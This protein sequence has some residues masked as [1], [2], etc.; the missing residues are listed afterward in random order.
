MSLEQTATCLCLSAIPCLLPTPTWPQLS[1]EKCLSTVN[2]SKDKAGQQRAAVS[3][4]VYSHGI[5]LAEPMG[6]Q[7]RFPPPVS[8]ILRHLVAFH[9]SLVLQE[10]DAGFLQRLI[11][12]IKMRERFRQSQMPQ[13]HFSAVEALGLDVCCILTHMPLSIAPFPTL[14]PLSS[15]RSLSGSPS[16]RMPLRSVTPQHQ[17]PVNAFILDKTHFIPQDFLNEGTG[18]MYI[19][20]L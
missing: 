8:I 5:A 1:M 6:H 2:V 9:T 19:F 10:G 4:R 7:A 11:S 18:C 20:H 13:T 14:L 16:I 12:T 3:S 15:P 17:H